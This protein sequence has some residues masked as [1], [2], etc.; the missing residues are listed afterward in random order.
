MD[1]VDFELDDE[2]WI[3]WFCQACEC[4]FQWMDKFSSNNPPTLFA[5]LASREMLRDDTVGLSV[6]DDARPLLPAFGAGM[7][8]YRPLLED[9]IQ[10]VE[11]APP[12]CKLTRSEKARRIAELRAEYGAAYW[13]PQQ[14]MY[15]WLLGSSSAGS[16][17]AAVHGTIYQPIPQPPTFPTKYRMTHATRDPSYKAANRL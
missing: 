13:R 5:S 2:D 7:F 3:K 10:M 15:G 1:R 14:D 4:W 17:G 16:S 11:Q 9:A 8:F 12:A 6:S